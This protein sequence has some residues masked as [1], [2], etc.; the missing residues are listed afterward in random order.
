MGFSTVNIDGCAGHIE[1]GEGRKL[2][3]VL[4][5]VDT[6]PEGEGWTFPPYSAHLENGKI[7][8]RGAFDDKGP[9]IAAIY[10]LKAIRDSGVS[11]NKRVRIIIGANEETGMNDIPKYLQSEEEPDL[12]F[13]PDA[14]FP[15]VYGEKG[16]VE[17]SFKKP[18]PSSSKKTRLRAL[19]G[20]ESVKKVPSRC[21]AVFHTSDEDRIEI[22]NTL[23]QFDNGFGHEYAYSSASKELTITMYGVEAYATNPENGKNAI[24]GMMKFLSTLTCIN[25]ELM[26]FSNFFTRRIGEEYDGTSLHCNFTDEISTPLTFNIG[27]IRYENEFLEMKAHIRYPILTNHE[28]IMRGIEESMNPEGIQITVERLS[29]P[30]Y[31]SRESYLVTTLLKVYRN[32]TGDHT[33]EPVTM[34]G[35]TYARTLKNAVGFGP[36]FPGQELVAHAPNE[37]LDIESIITAAK[38]YAKAMYEL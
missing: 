2:V 20:G 13:S 32:I 1:Y 16:I 30:L 29:K 23:D 18:I 12:A 27:S 9:C 38:I 3:G 24:A 35:G 37:Y 8:G 6:V 34:T 19:Y 4:V 11:M 5:H 17:L 10:A 25:D 14:P 36:L 33:A 26:R 7:F 22:V 15:V 31:F 21:T 28:V